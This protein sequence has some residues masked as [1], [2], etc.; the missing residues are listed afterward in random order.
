VTRRERC[1]VEL[2]L[3]IGTQCAIAWMLALALL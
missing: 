3:L 1:R 2:A